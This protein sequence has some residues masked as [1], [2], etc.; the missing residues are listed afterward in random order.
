MGTK[1]ITDSKKSSVLE[2]FGRS[3][4]EYRKAQ[5]FS[6]ESFAHYC[7][8][9][10]SYMGGVERGERNL[11]LTNIERIISALQM[12]PSDFF[13]PM[14]A[15]FQKIATQWQASQLKEFTL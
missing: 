4:R 13:L 8:L 5:G 7:G 12:K 3:V 10:R 2:A 11:T 1:N 15:H 14:D 6:Q 9:D